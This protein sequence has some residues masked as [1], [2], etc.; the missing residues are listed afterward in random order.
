ML[1][2]ITENVYY[3]N[4]SIK[5]LKET[6]KGSKYVTIPKGYA[7]KVSK[8]IGT[9]HKNT[10]L[11]ESIEKKVDEVFGETKLMQILEEGVETLHDG[12]IYLMRFDSGNRNYEVVGYDFDQMAKA[13]LKLYNKYCRDS[14]YTLKQL[15]TCEDDFMFR[16]FKIKV[17]E[18]FD[19]D[20]ERT[21]NNYI[22]NYLDKWR[23]YN[24]SC[25]YAQPYQKWNNK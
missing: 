3:L 11:V 14:K 18:A 22:G 24:T 9:G 21:L 23:P 6:D 10:W 17:G 1:Q 4:K 12:E 16:C 19:D 20:E 15:A 8:A 2:S 13:I 7:V 25:W 5:I